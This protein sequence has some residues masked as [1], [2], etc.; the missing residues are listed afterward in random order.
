VDKNVNNAFDEL[1]VESTLKFSESVSN[2]LA[3]MFGHN[4][5]PDKTPHLESGVVSD[6]N[7]F[8]SIFFT[9]MV[10]GE[11]ILAMNEETAASIIDLTIKDK[12]GAEHEQVRQEISAAFSEL[13]N[14]VV[15]ESIVGLIRVYQKMTLTPPRSFFGSVNYPKVMTGKTTLLSKND[16]IDCYLYVDRMKL[17][18][19]SSYK[20]ALV[21]VLHAHKELKEAMNKL[22]L[23]QMF[24]V[25]SEKMAALGTMAAGVAHEINTPLA[26]VSVIGDSLKDMI[27]ETHIEDK[28]KFLTSLDMIESTI[29]R[30]SKIT[31]GMRDFA[32]GV[33]TEVYIEILVKDLITAA[34]ISSDQLM[35]EE[36]IQFI[37]EAVSEDLFIE[38]RAPEISQVIF[39]LIHNSLDAVKS[40]PLKWIKVQA[41]DLG[42]K[43]E[44]RISDSG[45]GIPKEIYLKI[46]D[47]FFTTK[48]YGHG[49]GLGLSITKGVLESH[50]GEI[51]LDE[52]NPHTC[53][54]IRLPKKKAG[55]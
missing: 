27:I 53:F 11:Y 48:D 55:K 44:I 31:N 20:E 45:H 24:L 1:V 39:S 13:L 12:S 22:Q 38:C 42:D 50:N 30:I 10:Y 51:K 49:A 46:F 15:G 4:F 43:V 9:G 52:S 32:H 5:Q 54:I 33:R 37:N 28:T 7:F 41:I 40:A 23:Q 8:V 14:M 29:Q 21:K 47:P 35:M 3:A 19:A 2:V 36:N 16:S 26:T 6:K 34:L 25:Q 18:I 17:D